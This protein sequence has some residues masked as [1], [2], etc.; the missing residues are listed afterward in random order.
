MKAITGTTCLLAPLAIMVTPGC[1][2]D[3]VVVESGFGDSVRMMVIAQTFDPAAGNK[4]IVAVPLDGEYGQ[5]VLRR[6]RCDV[7]SKDTVSN[8]IIFNVGK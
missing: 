4:P 2:T 3:P 7:E 8:E 6:Y 5:S 1:A